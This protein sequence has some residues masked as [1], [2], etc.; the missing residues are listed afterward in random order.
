MIQIKDTAPPRENRTAGASASGW[1]GSWERD[2]ALRLRA[3]AMVTRSPF[4]P[5]RIGR[6]R[7]MAI[8]AFFCRTEIP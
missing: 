4:P 8:T 6:H 3:T 1:I 5:E 7:R 2:T